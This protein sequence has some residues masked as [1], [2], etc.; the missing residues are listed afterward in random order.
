MAIQNAATWGAQFTQLAANFVAEGSAAL[1]AAT[2][3]VL[4]MGMNEMRI[5]RA[6]GGGVETPPNTGQFAAPTDKDA[7]YASL[8]P[9][10]ERQSQTIQVSDL[11][12]SRMGGDKLPVVMQEQLGAVIR[13]LDG[14]VLGT[15][16]AGGYASAEAVANATNPVALGTTNAAAAI[17]RLRTQLRRQGV[18]FEGGT[19][20]LLLDDD[21][22]SELLGVDA[23]QNSAFRGDSGTVRSGEISD[24]LGFGRIYSSGNVQLHVA[25]S[26]AGNHA[27]NNS[28]GYPVGYDGFINED[29]GTGNYVAGDAV[30]FGGAS[31]HDYVYIVAGNTAFRLTVPLTRA[32]V[33]D[34]PILKVGAGSSPNSYRRNLAFPRGA[35]AIGTRMLETG[36]MG[37]IVQTSAQA[38]PGLPNF[39][40]RMSQIRLPRARQIV[41]DYVVDRVIVQPRAVAVLGTA[42]A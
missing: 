41:F 11:D 42:N 35:V 2:T 3:F 26:A 33:N 40:L 27:V 4:G 20:N 24:Y 21:D 25:G 30:R 7:R 6:P 1:R 31:G 39:G 14:Y 23:V 29:G 22:Y 15:P 13:D 37:T 38:A 36:N 5:P 17:R 34:A 16:E 19:V 8:N 28:S 10:R 18:Q 32:I 12:Y 9:T